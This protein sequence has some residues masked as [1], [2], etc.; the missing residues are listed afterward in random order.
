MTVEAFTL[1]VSLLFAGSKQKC[2]EVC[3]TNSGQVCSQKKVLLSWG[4]IK[5]KIR[6]KKVVNNP[7]KIFLD[8]RSPFLLDNALLDWRGNFRKGKIDGTDGVSIAGDFFSAFRDGF[9]LRISQGARG[10]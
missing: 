6:E 10:S 5:G 4:K 9:Q 1:G 7:Q 2:S 3:I 8:Y